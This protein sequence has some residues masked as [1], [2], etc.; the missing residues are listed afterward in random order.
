MIDTHFF[1]KAHVKDASMTNLSLLEEMPLD[2]ISYMLVQMSGL[3]ASRVRLCG[4]YLRRFGDPRK[5]TRL[6]LCSVYLVCVCL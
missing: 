4:G 5:N 1:V 6:Q 2:V 3:R